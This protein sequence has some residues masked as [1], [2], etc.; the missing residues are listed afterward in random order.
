MAVNP[1]LD[2]PDRHFA[3]VLRGANR[4]SRCAD[5]GIASVYDVAWRDGW[6]CAYC[7]RDLC[8]S[9][10]LYGIPGGAMATLDHVVAQRWGGANTNG[11]CVLACPSCNSRKGDRHPAYMFRE[12][13]A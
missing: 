13:A 8:S 10:T 4:K 5:R 9:D 6:T 1:F 12:V 11:N 3:P 2:W 7:G